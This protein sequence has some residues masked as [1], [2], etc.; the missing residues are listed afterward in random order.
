MELRSQL[1]YQHKRLL[2]SFPIK[3]SHN[4][5]LRTKIQYVLFSYFITTLRT[6][7]L[8]LN[9]I[10]CEGIMNIGSFKRTLHFIPSALKN[11]DPLSWEK[12]YGRKSTKPLM[13]C[14]LPLLLTERYGYPT[15]KNSSVIRADRSNLY[16]KTLMLLKM[17][18]GVLCTWR[19]TTT[20]VDDIFETK[21][22]QDSIGWFDILSR[23]GEQRSSGS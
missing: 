9:F 11:L 20:M 1:T 17:I 3:Q 19:N 23:Q 12:W 13:L 2:V 6:F 5:G 7:Q 4:Y 10:C 22:L 16:S 21:Q 8:Q 14:L 15:R 18:S